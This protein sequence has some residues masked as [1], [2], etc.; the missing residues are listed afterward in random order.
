PLLAFQRQAS[1]AEPF[2]SAPP[3]PLRSWLLEQRRPFFG[4]VNLV[5]GGSRCCCNFRGLARRRG[6]LFF[7]GCARGRNFRLPSG[8]LGLGFD[9]GHACCRGRRLELGIADSCRSLEPTAQFVEALCAALVP[10]LA[11]KLFELRGQLRRAA[12]VARAQSE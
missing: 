5:N 4:K 6:F 3:L 10:A 9:R 1:A 11:M 12:I 2:R 7:L 8:L